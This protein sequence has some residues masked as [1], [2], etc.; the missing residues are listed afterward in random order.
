MSGLAQTDGKKTF[1]GDPCNYIAAQKR[2][3]TQQEKLRT[4]QQTVH[5]GKKYPCDTCDFFVTQKVTL[6]T[7]TICAHRE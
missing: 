7:H 1:P 3:L 5:E 4:N 2:I 6:R